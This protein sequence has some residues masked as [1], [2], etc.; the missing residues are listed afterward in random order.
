MKKTKVKNKKR[1]RVMGFLLLGVLLAASVGILVLTYEPMLP[2]DKD[3]E[4]VG[5]S[6]IS[7]DG[8]SEV[9]LD[10]LYKLCK[11]WGYT[12][13][14]HPSVIDGTLNW[15]A[16]LF[17]VLPGVLAAETG[18]EA[19]QVLYEWLN[20]FPA[21]YERTESSRE[22]QEIQEEQGYGAADLSWISD[23]AFL[24]EDLSSYLESLADL[25]VAE[26]AHAYAS[27]DQVLQTVKFDGEETPFMDPSDDGMRLLALFRFW[28]AYG[29]YSPNLHLT[30][31]DWDTVLKESIP[32]MLQA[33]DHRS[34]VLA[35]AQIVAETADGHVRVGDPE[36]VCQRFYGDYSLP[37]SVQ[38]IDGQIVVQQVEE[39]STLQAGDILLAIDGMTMDARIQELS[40]YIALPEPEKFGGGMKGA[41][42]TTEGAKAQV[43]VSRDGQELELMVDTQEEFYIGKNPYQNGLLEDGRIGYLDPAALEGEKHVEELMEEFAST[44]GIIVDLRKY[45]SVLIV[46]LLGEYLIPEP[47]DF[48]FLTFPNQAYP[49]YFYRQDDCMQSGSGELKEIFRI[50]KTHPQYEGKVMLL[51]DEE[52]VSQSEF[53]IMALRQ[54]PNA[55]VIGSPSFGADGNVTSIG[56]PGN[57][58]VRFTGLGVYTP[59]GGQTQC[60]GLTPDVECYPT[61]EGLRQGRD[62]LVEKAVELILE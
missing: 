29:Y 51:M 48:A 54:S 13:Y 57:I 14:Y 55:T 1:R 46:Y 45:P 12:K 6:G 10:S 25:G 11:V 60:V 35:I 62:E 58:I 33:D 16:E 47:T 8:A 31:T 59:E 21:S 43:L 22:W 50:A 39:S 30:K 3:K 40:R 56:L 24:G 37:C 20:Q 7:V 23:R 61:V 44:E 5:G 19:N 26:R 41:L 9:Q 18:E 42:L 34:Y 52:S 27:F 36:N 49:G 4:F 2:R 38:R 15:N 53:T 17:R 28:N 32:V